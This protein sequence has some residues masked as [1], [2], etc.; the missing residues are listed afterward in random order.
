M[1]QSQCPSTMSETFK[2][3]CLVRY[4]I[5]RRAID[6]NGAK[7]FLEKWMIKHPKSTLEADVLDQWRK[8]NR[9]KDWK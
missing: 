6:R 7:N 2:H 9:G 3:Q 4:V 8:G 5:K 1:T